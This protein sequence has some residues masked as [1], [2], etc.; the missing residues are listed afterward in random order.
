MSD[1]VTRAPA[2]P[3]KPLLAPEDWIACT[4]GGGII[5]GILSLFG[6]QAYLHCPRELSVSIVGAIAGAIALLV[7]MAWTKKA[8]A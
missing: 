4:I 1:T 7:V 2:V 6:Y 5:G 3:V 8:R